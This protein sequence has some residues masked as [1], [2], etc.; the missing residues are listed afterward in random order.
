MI[1]GASVEDTL[2]LWASS[3]RDVKVRIRPLFTQDRVAASA[4]DFLD[5]LSRQ[6]TSQDR[7]D[8]CGGCG[9][10]W[11]MATASHF[12]SRTLGCRCLAD[13][14]REYVLEHL[15]AD[16]AVL[17]IDETGFLK[18]GRASCGV[19]RHYTGSTGKITNGQIGVFAAYTKAL[20]V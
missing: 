6:R 17:V 4:G 8:A 18:Q 14:V 3:L 7:L 12:G 13:V 19:G 9:R 11:P 2:E 20:K 1:G 16:D 5:T 10:F 15:A